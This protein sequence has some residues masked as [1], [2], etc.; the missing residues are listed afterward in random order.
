[1]WLFLMMAATVSGVVSVMVTWFVSCH[2][3]ELHVEC[4]VE[5]AA[6][7]GGHAGED[8]GQQGQAVE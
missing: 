8:A 5:A 2:V 1:V 6:Q 3:D 4:L 7:L